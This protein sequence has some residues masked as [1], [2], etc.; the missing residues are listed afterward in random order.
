LNHAV[1]IYIISE[2]TNTIV[3]FNSASINM[4]ISTCLCNKQKRTRG[5]RTRKKQEAQ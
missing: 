3:Q 1:G 2:Y 4:F 5:W